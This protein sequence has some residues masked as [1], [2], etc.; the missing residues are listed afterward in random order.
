MTS[1]EDN[2]FISNGVSVGIDTNLGGTINSFDLGLEKEPSL[3]GKSKWRKLH[4][5]IPNCY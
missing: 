1:I 4:G 3:K 2:P 5:K